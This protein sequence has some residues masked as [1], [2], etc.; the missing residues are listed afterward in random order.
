MGTSGRA[1]VITPRRTT[2]S[3]AIKVSI[4]ALMGL[5]IGRNTAS[6][7]PIVNNSRNSR[8]PMMTGRLEL[9]GPMS[10]ANSNIPAALRINSSMTPKARAI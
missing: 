1:G 2:G 8:L 4:E 7:T 9:D 5:R 6:T 10:I 3:M